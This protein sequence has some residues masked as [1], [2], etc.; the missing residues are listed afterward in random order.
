MIPGAKI[1]SFFFCVFLVNALSPL[2][3]EET[4]PLTRDMAT[5][6][7]VS[8]ELPLLTLSPA[9][10]VGDNGWVYV[11]PGKVSLSLKP[12]D[13]HH[14]EFYCMN[15]QTGPPPILLGIDAYARDGFK[16]SHRVFSHS[17]LH[18]WAEAYTSDHQR[19]FSNT[20]IVRTVE[21]EPSDES[22]TATR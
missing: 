15:P 6:P 19:Y 22:Y 1:F 20:V 10:Y 3:A 11:K 2:A 17:F 9:V 7:G 16:T 12:C 8:P 21:P 4:T 18:Y 13:Y 5:T 14:V